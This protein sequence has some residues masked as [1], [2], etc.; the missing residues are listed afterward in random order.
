MLEMEDQSVTGSHNTGSKNH[1]IKDVLSDLVH[2]KRHD[3]S[4]NIGTSQSDN[5]GEEFN[6]S[7][8][9]ESESNVSNSTSSES[10]SD[11][12]NVLKADELCSDEKVDSEVIHVSATTEDIPEH[13]FSK[14]ENILWRFDVDSVRHARHRKRLLEIDQVDG[15][16]RVF[17]RIHS[18]VPVKLKHLS[19]KRSNINYESGTMDEKSRSFSE[20]INSNSSIS[21][22]HED[23]KTKGLML[24]KVYLLEAIKGSERLPLRPNAVKIRVDVTSI[25]LT[26]ETHKCREMFLQLVDGFK[27]SFQLNHSVVESTFSVKDE[28]ESVGVGG[29]HEKHVLQESSDGKKELKVFCSTF[30]CA[31]TLTSLAETRNWFAQ[32]H[33]FDLVAIALQECV[34]TLGSA[35]STTAAAAGNVTDTASGLAAAAAGAVK[36]NRDTSTESD[37]RMHPA[38]SVDF[39]SD[40]TQSEALLRKGSFSANTSEPMLKMMEHVLVGELQL[41]RVTIRKSWNRVLAIYKRKGMEVSVKRVGATQLGAGGVVGNKGAISALL[42][43]HDTTWIRVVCAHFAAHAEHVSDRNANYVSIRKAIS[44]FY[45]QFGNESAARDLSLYMPPHHEIW[46]GDFNYRLSANDSKEVLELIEKKDWLALLARDQLR[47]E[48]AVGNVFYGLSEGPI[49]FPP[50]FKYKPYSV[51]YDKIKGRVPSYC[52]RILSQSLPGLSIKYRKY[53]ALTDSVTCSDHRPVCAH[54]DVDIVPGAYSDVSRTQ[55]TSRDELKTV[56]ELVNLPLTALNIQPQK[57]YASAVTVDWMEVNVLRGS[58]GKWINE[59]MGEDLLNT[60]GFRPLCSADF[61]SALFPSSIVQTS[62]IRV[63][64]SSHVLRFERVA[65]PE[66]T[67]KNPHDKDSAP[68][69]S[70]V[71]HEYIAIAIFVH[72]LGGNRRAEAQYVG[73]AVISLGLARDASLCSVISRNDHEEQHKTGKGFGLN[74]LNNAKKLIVND[75]LLHHNRSASHN[76]S[77]S[78]SKHRD[79]GKTRGYTNTVDPRHQLSQGQPK[80]L[81]L[82]PFSVPITRFGLKVGTLQ[83]EF[84]L[85]VSDEP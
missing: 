20:N 61:G 9:A 68:T 37:E 4:E 12:D 1:P 24:K 83:G 54:L 31:A 16:L 18:R 19:S 14:Q 79:F 27:S 81:R 40:S 39:G 35:A 3:N 82:V 36:P 73:G 34:T 21:R 52:D 72:Q 15:K 57:M 55:S 26:F 60:V 76:A 28:I 41:E 65:I 66:F 78:G 25:T 48:R 62:K 13:K 53:Y 58:A 56:N 45:S 43:V 42:W 8:N 49:D 29:V 74:H 75:H 2:S 69:L 38:L 5:K 59:L 23:V 7:M 32:L 77:T 22:N 80:D 50:T 10:S 30:N 85:H 11:D 46:L 67:L 71:F 51:E 63:M 70:H 33:G 47:L 17:K 84:C 6:L 64:P 44:M